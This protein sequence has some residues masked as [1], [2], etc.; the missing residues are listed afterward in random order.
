MT[1]YQLVMPAHMNPYGFLFGGNM[2][3]WV[4]EYAWLAASR[5]YPHMRFVTVGMDRVAFKKQVPMGA[6][7]R[8]E[9]LRRRE[10]RTSVVYDVTVTNDSDGAPAEV[11]FETEITFVRVDDSGHKLPLKTE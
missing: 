9:T 6:I 8:F 1:T 4:D 5:D 7:L 11:L 2:L 10:G 3:K